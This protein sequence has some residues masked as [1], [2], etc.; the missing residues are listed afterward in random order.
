MDA[1]VV[2]GGL[3]GLAGERQLGARQALGEDRLADP[4][5]R[6]P[7]LHGFGPFF[8][9]LSSSDDEKRAKNGEVVT[10]P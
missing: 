4:D 2:E 8:A 6:R 10:S 7:V 9:R 1:G 3:D 5:D